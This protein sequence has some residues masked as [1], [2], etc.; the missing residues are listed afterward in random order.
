MTRRTR[1][2]ERIRDIR[3]ALTPPIPNPTPGGPV[4]ACVACGRVLRAS[5]NG[6][7]RSH[8]PVVRGNR[9]YYGQGV[10]DGTFFPGEPV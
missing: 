3:G 8:S 9:K 2:R 1:S 7:P 10:C 4:V 5:K 6:H